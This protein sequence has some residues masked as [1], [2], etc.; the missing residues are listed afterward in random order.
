MTH[1]VQQRR[2]IHDGLFRDCNNETVPQK[3]KFPHHQQPHGVFTNDHGGCTSR[4]SIRIPI[5]WPFFLCVCVTT[6]RLS[7]QQRE[8]YTRLL[9]TYQ[10]VL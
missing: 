6:N 4:G 1:M 5:L 8:S 7:L 10:E 3:T 9:F 2:H